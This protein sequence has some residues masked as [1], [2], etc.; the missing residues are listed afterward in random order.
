MQSNSCTK[1]HV[2][3]VAELREALSRP[4]G[5]SDIENLRPGRKVGIRS[6]LSVSTLALSRVLVRVASAFFACLPVSMSPH[7][8]SLA[9]APIDPAGDPIRP[10]SARSPAAAVATAAGPTEAGML[11]R[12]IAL[13]GISNMV[14]LSQNPKAGR[15][16]SLRPSS[17]CNGELRAAAGRNPQVGS[18]N[19]ASALSTQG[20]RTV[21]RGV[22]GSPSDD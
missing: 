3:P 15:A 12:K 8:D 11:G 19:R 4:A 2:L 7:L 17:K 13:A 14:S 16:G 5:Q 10:Q 9:P 6:N 18:G 22:R 20:S 1:D 21:G